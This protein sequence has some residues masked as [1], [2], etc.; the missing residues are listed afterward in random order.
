M[1]VAGNVKTDIPAVTMK[2][3]YLSNQQIVF[4]CVHYYMYVCNGVSKVH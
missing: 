2:V 3:E 1:A 4:F